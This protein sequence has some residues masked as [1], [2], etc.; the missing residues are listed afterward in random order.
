MTLGVYISFRIF[1]FPDITADGSFTLGAAVAAV[2][3]VGGT[4][5]WLAIAIVFLAGMFAGSITGILHTKFE[6]HQLLAGIIVMTALYSVNLHIMGKS[7]ISLREPLPRLSTASLKD[8]AALATRIREAKDPLSAYLLTQLS[9]KTQKALEEHAESADGRTKGARAIP[10]SLAQG[11]VSDLNAVIRGN[12]LFDEARFEHVRLSRPTRKILRLD[13]AGDELAKL[14]RMLLDDAYRGVVTRFVE[15]RTISKQANAVADRLAGGRSDLNV[16]GW[17]LP[18]SDLS[19]LIGSLVVVVVIAVL[20]YLFFQTNLGTAMRATGDNPDMIRALGVN[21]ESMI[22][23]GLAVS[24]GLIAVS[25]GMFAQYMTF[26]DVQMGFGVIVAGL[27]SVIIGESL[28]GHRSLG[29]T[30]V[31]AIMGALLFRLFLA[32]A[33]RWGLPPEDLKLAQAL[34]LFVALVVPLL[35]RKLKKK[36]GIAHA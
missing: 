31:G 28:V 5:P 3:A 27:A 17:D 20:L 32:I 8:P 19:Q 22:I 4:N 34:I 9:P 24:N 29:L 6:I 12:P 18:V 14:N 13:P 36:L 25:G 23:L 11:L 1:A 7:N 10:E 26:A 16:F 2:L 30:I 15:V 33:L 21:V 35:L